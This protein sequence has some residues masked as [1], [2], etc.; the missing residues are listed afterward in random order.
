MRYEIINS[1]S[2]R[3][4]P[5]TPLPPDKSLRICMNLMG[6]PGRG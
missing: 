3:H 5:P 2:V 1:D 6:G 4:L